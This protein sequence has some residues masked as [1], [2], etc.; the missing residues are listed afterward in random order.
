MKGSATY[1]FLKYSTYLLQSP[2]THA[3]QSFLAGASVLTLRPD[4]RPPHCMLLNTLHPSNTAGIMNKLAIFAFVA[5]AL[6]AVCPQYSNGQGVFEGLTNA[7][8][9]VSQV[10]PVV[11]VTAAFYR[12]SV[13]SLPPYAHTPTRP[14]AALQHTHTQYF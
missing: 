8:N 7:V 11:S 3:Q 10:R 1:G 12:P 14:R 2:S 9:S 13:L 6:V 4:L 5:V